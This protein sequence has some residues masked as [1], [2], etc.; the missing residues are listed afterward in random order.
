MFSAAIRVL[1]RAAAIQLEE[2]AAAHPRPPRSILKGKERAIPIRRD[3]RSELEQAPTTTDLGEHSGTEG[4]WRERYAT[5]ISSVAADSNRKPGLQENLESLTSELSVE[6]TNS[7]AGP[8]RLPPQA[9]A[10]RQT[11][12]AAHVSSEADHGQSTPKVV[13]EID[14]TPRPEPVASRSSR[15]TGMPEMVEPAVAVEP[16]VSVDPPTSKSSKDA[17]PAPGAVETKGP[18][19]AVTSAEKIAPKSTVP[20]PIVEEDIAPINDTPASIAEE[21]ED[22][23]PLSQVMILANSRCRRRW[24]FVLRRYLRLV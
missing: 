24:Y 10:H 21:A 7:T 8:S 19:E 16:T 12:H 2:V 1:S 11:A 20:E 14:R 13:T 18:Q 23:R 3:F 5:P 17:A 9:E 4:K 15:P 6:T 22:V